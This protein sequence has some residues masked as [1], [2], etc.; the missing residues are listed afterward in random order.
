MRA[1]L[2][3]ASVVIKC[4]DKAN[5]EYTNRQRIAVA[6]ERNVALSQD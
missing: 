6:A 1:T 2:F 4:E 3:T 5:I